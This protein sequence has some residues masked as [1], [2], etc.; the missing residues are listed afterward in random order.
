VHHSSQTISCN[1]GH[2]MSFTRVIQGFTELIALFVIGRGWMYR[3]PRYHYT[4]YTTVYT[5]VS[6]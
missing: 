3:Y 1:C 4:V 6:F 5:Q 2:K